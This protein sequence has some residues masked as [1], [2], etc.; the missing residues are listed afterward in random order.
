MTFPQGNDH[1][2]PRGRRMT[3]SGGEE[4]HV[5]APAVSAMVV[6]GGVGRLTRTANPGTGEV[7][8]G[9]RR[10]GGVCE[11]NAQLQTF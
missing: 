11:R 1:D 8:V 7:I 3:V 4:L 10:H 5:K 9:F 6:G 2:D